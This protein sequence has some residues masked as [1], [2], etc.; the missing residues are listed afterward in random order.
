MRVVGGVYLILKR[1][2]RNI[3]DFWYTKQ[4][5]VWAWIQ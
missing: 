1:W 4:R 5:I 2:I 3:L